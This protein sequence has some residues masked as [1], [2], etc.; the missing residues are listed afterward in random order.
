MIRASA[1][2]PGGILSRRLRID[3]TKCTVDLCPIER[4]DGGSLKVNVVAGRDER[5]IDFGVQTDRY[6]TQLLD[7]A[8]IVRGDKPNDQDYGRDLL[9]HE[10]T[11]R[12]CGV[13]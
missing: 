3:G 7:L 5:T 6:A 8:A 4:F 9:V 10:M 2:R 13:L 12:A 11:L 1:Y